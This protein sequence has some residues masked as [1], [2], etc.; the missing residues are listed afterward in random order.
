MSSE[1]CVTTINGRPLDWS[2]T[3]CR[4]A[5]IGPGHEADEMNS[6]GRTMLLVSHSAQDVSRYTDRTLYIRDG[7]LVAD[8]PTDDVIAMYEADTD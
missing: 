8:G 3:R 2:S 6:G 4:V 1:F 7:R 5:S